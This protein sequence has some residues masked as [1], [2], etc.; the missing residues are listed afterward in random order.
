MAFTKNLKSTNDSTPNRLYPQM[1]QANTNPNPNKF[2][3]NK[4]RI[5]HNRNRNK[6][7]VKKNTEKVQQ[8]HAYLIFRYIRVIIIT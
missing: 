2:K 3:G 4:I 6:K 8:L 5:I 7:K 1:I